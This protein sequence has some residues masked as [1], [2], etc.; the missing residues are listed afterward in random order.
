M[1]AYDLNEPDVLDLLLKLAAKGRVRL[2]L[3]NAALHHNA[4]RLQTRG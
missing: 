4:D 2:I 1:F 3:D